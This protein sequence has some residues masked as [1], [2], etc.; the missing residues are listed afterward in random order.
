MDYGVCGGWT[1]TSGTAVAHGTALQMGH[2]SNS[3]KNRLRKVAR[4]SLC[5]VKY[6]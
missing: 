3:V 5:H 1:R 6:C 2:G 4:V